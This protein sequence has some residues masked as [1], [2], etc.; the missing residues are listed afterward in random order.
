E[1]SRYFA[2]ISPLTTPLGLS[3]SLLLRS[4][5]VQPSSCHSVGRETF[6][7]AAPIYVTFID[8]LVI[9]VISND[10][11]FHCVHV[12]C[13][14]RQLAPTDGCSRCRSSRMMC[15]HTAVCLCSLKNMHHFEMYWGFGFCFCYSR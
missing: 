2:L 15:S 6:N 9:F 14:I 11:P 5:C 4:N 12:T 3:R 10:K 13:Q 7:R 8:W 1:L